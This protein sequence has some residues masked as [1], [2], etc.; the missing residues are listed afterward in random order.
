VEAFTEHI[1]S[2]DKNIKFTREDTKDNSLPFLD[3][4]VSID[5]NGSLSIEVYWKPTHMDQYLLFDS[6]R[7]LDHKLG[8]R[9]LQYR[10]LRFPQR[11]RENRKN[12]HTSRQHLKP[13][14]T[15]SGLLSNLQKGVTRK[16]RQ[17]QINR[18][19]NRETLS[20]HM[21]QAYLKNSE[22]SSTNTSISN[23]ARL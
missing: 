12:C 14:A 1:N 19:T 4:A 13:V 9:T 5:E 22:E 10:A 18:T 23:L 17:L 7:P 20:S 8:V 16:H 21:W 6:H 3:C 2:V 11:Q 15:L